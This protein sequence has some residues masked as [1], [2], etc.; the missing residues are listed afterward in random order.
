MAAHEKYCEMTRILTS[1]Y[2]VKH[3][4]PVT[5]IHVLKDYL[6]FTMPFFFLRDDEEHC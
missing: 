6:V 4:L 3:E 1:V 5:K 2:I